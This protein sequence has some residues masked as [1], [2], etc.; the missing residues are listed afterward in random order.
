MSLLPKDHHAMSEFDIFAY[1]NVLKIKHFR[2]I[3]MRDTMPERCWV[4]ECGVVNLDSIEGPGTHWVAYCKM[5]D[6]VYYFDSFGNLPPPI[7]LIQYFGNNRIFYN[8]FN[9][10]KFNTVICGQ[11]CLV[12]LCKIQQ[13]FLNKKKIF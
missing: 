13:K 4:N 9:Y 5:Q 11:L 8:N 2:G 6:I 7:E 3:F 12:F 10:Q 1:A